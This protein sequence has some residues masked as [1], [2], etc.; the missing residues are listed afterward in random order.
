MDPL[1]EYLAKPSSSIFRFEGLQDYSAMDGTAAIKNFIATGDLGMS[2]ADTEWCQDIKKKNE[3]GIVT[4]RVRMVAHPQNDYTTWELAWHKA[5]AEFSGDDI[6]IIAEE[7]F[8]KI[9]PKGLKD[10]WMIDDKFVFVL[11]Y[12]PKGSYLGSSMLSK[13]ESIPYIAAKKA[14]LQSSSPIVKWNK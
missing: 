11:N 10:F 14:L 6:R 3:A 9:L 13:A 1:T 12:G 4:Q 7:D 5:A 8:K 2:P